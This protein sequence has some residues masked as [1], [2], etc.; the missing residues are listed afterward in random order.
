MFVSLQF[1]L[2]RGRFQY[3]TFHTN[4]PGKIFA[5]HTVF[6]QYLYN[7]LIHYRFC[8]ECGYAYGMGRFNTAYVLPQLLYFL[9]LFC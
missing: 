7:T 8:L 3:L 4:L 5:S 6:V 1:C 9:D 2:P